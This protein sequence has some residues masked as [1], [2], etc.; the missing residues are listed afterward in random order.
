VPSV[1]E[2]W[3]VSVIEANAM[4][5]PAIGYAVPGLRDSIVEGVTGALVRPF[6]YVAMA[7]AAKLLIGDQGNLE[8]MSRNCLD[9]A[10]KF[11]W[12]DAATAFHRLL[13]SRISPIA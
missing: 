3:G 11:S 13:E 2:G 10:R 7:G 8:K 5:T 9:W 4:G 1:R 6:D 12:D